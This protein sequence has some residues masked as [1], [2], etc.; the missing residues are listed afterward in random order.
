MLTLSSWTGLQLQAIPAC[1]AMHLAQHTTAT[2]CKLVLF[3]LCQRPLDKVEMQIIDVCDLIVM[4][5]D[6][7]ML[8]VTKVH[9]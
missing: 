6:A 4:K 3:L 2:A 5:W 9:W 1:L 7:A 8:H